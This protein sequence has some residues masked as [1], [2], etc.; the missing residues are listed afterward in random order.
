M[1]EAEILRHR[2]CKNFEVFSAWKIVICSV[3]TNR[4]K[5]FGIFRKTVLL[6]SGLG[7]LSSIF[8]TRGVV[9]LAKPPLF[10]R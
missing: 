2:R 8:V 4:F 7:D 10:S 1:S 5:N 3:H 6:E 9:K